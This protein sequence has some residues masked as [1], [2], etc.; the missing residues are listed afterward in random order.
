MALRPTSSKV[1]AAGLA[2]RLDDPDQRRMAVLVLRAV[3]LVLGLAAL[4]AFL[5][6]MIADMPRTPEGN[7]DLS[8]VLGAARDTPWAPLI[9]VAVYVLLNFAGVPQFLL[10]GGTVIVFGPWTGFVYA[11]CATMISSSVGFWLGH[12][13]GGELF[14]RFG[15]GTANQL[16]ARIARHGVLASAIV[17]VVPAGPAIMVNMAA[18]L[19]HISYGKFLLG[20]GLGI[21]PKILVIALVGKGISSFLESG[22]G[23]ALAAIA[24][25][26]V[27]WI[28][29]MILARRV[30]KRWRAAQPEETA[31]SQPPASP[32]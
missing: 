3:L 31:E 30:F 17:R 29:A 19:S 11:W 2:A 16:S 4:L 26:V 21:A 20:T 28:V 8:A 9:V 22:S 7:L 5:G 18:G 32:S 27:L 15:G 13:F 23:L 14:R 25:L 24:G 10:V 1:S 12:F 6:T